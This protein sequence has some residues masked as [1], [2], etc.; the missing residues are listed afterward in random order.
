LRA[1]AAQR[2]SAHSAAVGLIALG[3]TG[4]ADQAQA[5]MGQEWEAGPGWSLR[6]TPY[7]WMIGIEGDLATLSGV[8]PVEVDWSF[9]DVLD[10]LDLAF[11]SFLEAR[12]G[13]FSI[14]TELSYLR[15]GGEADLR[16][17]LLDDVE[18]TTGVLFVTGLGTYEALA[19]RA[20]RLDAL[21]GARA[22]HAR[23]ELE[24]G[25]G[26]LPGRTVDESEVWVDPL[27]GARI[28][29]DLGR[30]LSATGLAD[31]GGFDVGSTVTWEVMATLG[32]QLKDWIFAHAGYRHMRVDY[33]NGDFLYDV[34]LS[35]PI[36]GATFRF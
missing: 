33:E 15:L 29:I 27:V 36:V 6:L 4:W 30:G 18:L 7:L 25:P 11:T 31:L 16:G 24:F 19:G 3:L 26:L 13:A 2:R 23:T 35:G 28:R 5:Q 12:H 22:W 8:P 17:P 9:G 14:L 34:E 10:N 1:L 21:A 32:Y 20:W